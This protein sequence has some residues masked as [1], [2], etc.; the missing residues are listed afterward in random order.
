MGLFQALIKTTINVVSLPVTLPIKL[1]SDVVM[2]ISDAVEEEDTFSRTKQLL[3]K[4]KE[5]ASDD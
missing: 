3:E 2:F 5:E 4:I 1:T